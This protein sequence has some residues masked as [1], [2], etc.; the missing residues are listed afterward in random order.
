MAPLVSLVPCC[1][2]RSR[3]LLRGRQPGPG[4]VDTHRSRRD[5]GRTDRFNRTVRAK[6]FR[7]PGCPGGRYGT[8]SGF[9]S[10]M[11]HVKSPP[12]TAV[13]SPERKHSNPMATCPDNELMAASVARAVR[14]FSALRVPVRPPHDALHRH[15]R[16]A[17]HRWKP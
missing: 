15:R 17:D 11:A 13:T 3:P 10:R 8:R 16:G 6:P 1:V 12:D 9:C 14:S 7:H 4:R 5:A 2:G